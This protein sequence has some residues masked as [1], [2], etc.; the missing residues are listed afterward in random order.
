MVKGVPWPQITNLCLN[1]GLSNIPNSRQFTLAYQILLS[2]FLVEVLPNMERSII[3]NTLNKR[4]EKDKKAGVA[5]FPLFSKPVSLRPEP[6]GGSADG[7]SPAS[8]VSSSAV[9][10]EV[11]EFAFL[12]NADATGQENH[13]EILYQLSYQGSP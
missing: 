8:R 2:G 5:T 11:H 9:L 7:G 6:P 13:F 1:S 12:T 3:P 10:S 4:L